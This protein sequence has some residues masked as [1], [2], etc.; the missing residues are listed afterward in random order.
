MR[1]VYEMLVASVGLLALY[2]ITALVYILCI[3]IGQEI[4]MI[5]KLFYSHLGQETL[6][7]A[8][9]IAGIASTVLLST[10]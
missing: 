7:I 5:K 4:K 1:F 2:T 3:S 8:A 10:L 6:I 9:C